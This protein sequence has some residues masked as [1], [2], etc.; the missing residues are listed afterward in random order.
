MQE[1]KKRRKERREP[2]FHASLTNLRV[3]PRK[4]QLIADLVRGRSAQAA[5][6]ELRFAHRKYAE[7]VMKLIQSAVAQASQQRS[8]DVDRLFV[9]KISVHRAVVMKRFMARARGSADTILKRSA[10]IKLILDQKAA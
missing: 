9:K 8:V 6:D 3:S 2:G 10:H 7:A 1:K 4:L 5:I